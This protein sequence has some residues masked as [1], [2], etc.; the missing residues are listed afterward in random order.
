MTI[1]YPISNLNDGLLNGVAGAIGSWNSPMAKGPSG[2]NFVPRPIKFQNVSSDSV[3]DLTTNFQKIT[4]INVPI[5]LE[6]TVNSGVFTTLYINR[7]P[8]I[9]GAHALTGAAS[10]RII[11]QPDMFIAVRQVFSGSAVRTYT[12]Y[13]FSDRRTQ[14][15]SFTL[16]YLFSP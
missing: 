15:D 14:L 9:L 7:Q 6:I 4:G 5:E 3:N 1:R 16:E 13:N 2:P 11:V 10:L 8:T 12:V